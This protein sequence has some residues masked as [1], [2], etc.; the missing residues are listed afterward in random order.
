MVFDV[1]NRI[2]LTSLVSEKDALKALSKLN[3]EHD[4]KPKEGTFYISKDKSKVMYGKY[5]IF[6]IRGWGRLIGSGGFKL[7]SEEA[8]ETQGAFAKWVIETLNS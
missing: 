6:L 5:P 8:I 2:C 1:E 4:R 7:S 3:G